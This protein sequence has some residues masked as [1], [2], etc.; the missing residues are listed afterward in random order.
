[1]KPLVLV[2]LSTKSTRN[3]L[4]KG[5]RKALK[6][7][8]S[9]S[10]IVSRKANKKGQSGTVVSKESNFNYKGKVPSSGYIG[11]TRFDLIIPLFLRSLGHLYTQETLS[12]FISLTV[13][14]HDLLLSNH[15]IVDGTA[16]WKIITSYATALLE[17][18]KPENP[19]WVSTG[20]K[21]G[22]PKALTH[23]RPLYHFIIDNN[24]NDEMV[25]QVTESRRLINTLLHLNRV[26]SANRTLDNLNNLKAK[27]RLEPAMVS[28]FEKFT[29]N[30]LS[31]AREKITLTDLSFDL[32]LG[33]S[34]GP[35]GKPKLE[36]AAAEANLLVKDETLYSA[37]KDLCTITAN[38]TFLSF[39][40]R[41]SK[42]SNKD[43]SRILL[44]KL[45]SVPDK[46][47]KSR[48]I[49]I[50]DF[51]TQS[52]LNSVEKV[53]VR[54]TSNLFKKECCFFSH[55]AGWT[56]V[57]SQP[58]EVR[59]RLVSLDASNWTDNLPASLQYIVMKALFGQRL[60]DAWKALAVSCPWFVQPK[61]RPI[62][63][64]K[65]Q[66]M[67]TKGSFAIAQLTNLIFIKF[68]LQEL[69]PD[70]PNPYV[71]NVGDDLILEDPDMLFVKRYESI[72]VPI[73]LTKSK[74][75]TDLGSFTEFVS[76]NAWNGHDYSSIS[77]GLLSKFLRNDHYGPT[78][79]HHIKERDVNHPT[80]K[81]LYT[82][83][84]GIVQNSLNFELVEHRFNNVFK[85]TTL[86]DLVENTRL[87]EYPDKEWEDLSTEKIL[88]FLENLIL[89]TLGDLV[90][91]ATLLMG[92]RD[93]KIARAK[94]ELLLTRYSLVSDDLSIMGF[95]ESNSMSLVEAASAVQTLSVVQT[96]RDNADKGIK[97]IV[98][99]RFVFRDVHTGIVEID[100]QALDFILKTQDSLL[101][102]VLGYKTLTRLSRF[103]KANTKSTLALYRYLT[104]VFKQD[105]QVLSLDTGAYRIPYKRVPEYIDLNPEWIKAYAELFK[106]DVM[107]NQIQ[108]I[109]QNHKNLDLVVKFDYQELG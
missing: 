86:L 66:G 74:V 60:A 26:C 69:Y 98:P 13:R 47:N 95:I 102:T 6:K 8:Q 9:K 108:D 25:N 19:G 106:F 103:D 79:Y 35:N 34:N 40:E 75:H 51:W 76:R 94:A 18:R 15:G 80:F 20:R 81:E 33:P 105:T 43:V 72:G 67:G 48:V 32:F 3:V 46:G 39:F 54:V 23:L 4:P 10:K 24:H 99:E 42:D 11:R 16:R 36:T 62:Y 68:S 29:R 38:S 52:I 63:Y 70:N 71:M 64:G 104:Y 65:G 59:Q 55:S 1:M 12:S 27:F 83:K 87:I 41:I 61:T 56:N 49:A 78:L 45:T 53:V 85:L 89:S 96:A 82:M 91:Q 30:F 50:C 107:L 57:Q 109:R 84:K 37:L 101:R 44:R 93:S 77:P 73:N 90:N 92:N 2:S 100:S 21:D 58:V 7:G 14:S 31:E 97:T 28:R 22:W 17:G 88:L 5:V